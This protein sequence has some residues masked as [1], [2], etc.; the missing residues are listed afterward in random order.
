M[1]TNKR[2]KK[3]KGTKDFMVA[4][5][6]CGFVCLWAIRDA[7]FPT[8]KILKK[9]PLEF[10]I[11]NTVPGVIN[12]IPVEV[13]DEV[14]G[15]RPLMIFGSQ[16]YETAVATA[17]EAYREAVETKNKQQIKSTLDVLSQAEEDL[18]ST[19]IRCSDFVL[20]TTHGEESIKGKVL[21]ILVEPATHIGAGETVML[22]QPTDTFYIFNQSLAV[23]TFF[24]MIAALFFH[25]IAS[26]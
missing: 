12:S 18:K 7:W 24:G 11:T 16:H 25:R 13:G 6:A 14:S 23:L 5:V 26:K 17:K 4:A 19:I 2:L 1:A 15:D 9:H 21:E 3:I 22:V 8:E 20:E 10:A